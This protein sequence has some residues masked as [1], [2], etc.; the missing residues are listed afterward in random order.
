MFGWFLALT[1]L[2][3]GGCWIGLVWVWILIGGK[4]FG[5]GWV[6]FWGGCFEWLGGCF[7]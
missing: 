1:G 7:W 2:G 5:F 6:K 3:V 4:G